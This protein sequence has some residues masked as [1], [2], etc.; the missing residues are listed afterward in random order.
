MGDWLT[1]DFFSIIVAAFFVG[2][3]VG[4]TGMGGGAL[5]TPALIF[6]GVGGAS[7][8]VTADLTAAAIYKSGGAITHAREGQPNWTLAKWLI[9]GSVPFALVGPWLLHRAVGDSGDLDTRP[10]EVHRL[11]AAVRGGDVRPAPGDQPAP[12][13][14]RRPR[15][16]PRPPHP[17][18]A[19]DRDRRAGRPARRHHQRRLR[20]GDHDLAGHALPRP[21]RAAAGRHRPRAGRAAGDRGRHLQH[22][23]Q[24]PRLAH[25]GPAGDRLD[26]GHASWAAGSRP[27]SRSRSSAAAS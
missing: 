6:L 18:A 9:I 3:I 1:S 14:R 4:L 2:T 12:G 21:V 26:A 8:V 10:E 17:A 16:R 15:G 7:T 25:P 24:R 20:L 5:M 11:R 22:R 23:P 27:R 13:A 19:D